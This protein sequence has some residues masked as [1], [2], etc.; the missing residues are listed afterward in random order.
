M[1]SSPALRPPSIPARPASCSLSTPYGLPGI[2]TP[3]GQKGPHRRLEQSQNCSVV[4]FAA[5]VE[6]WGRPA[7]FLGPRCTQLLTV[8][9]W[10]YVKCDQGCLP[11]SPPIRRLGLWV[12]QTQ[13]SRHPAS[14]VVS[15]PRRLLIQSSSRRPNS[16]PDTQAASM[17]RCVTAGTWYDAYEEQGI[18]ISCLAFLQLE[19]L[20]ESDAA[21]PPSTAGQGV[22]VA[23]H[24]ERHPSSG[25]AAGE[26]DSSAGPSTSGRQ[27]ASERRHHPAD[28]MQG[29]NGSSAAGAMLGRDQHDQVGR[30]GRPPP[31][32]ELERDMRRLLDGGRA[33]ATPL[34]LA[35]PVCNLLCSITSSTV[36]FHDSCRYVCSSANCQSCS[37]SLSSI[38]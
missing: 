6:Q 11:A 37:A 4:V 29:P 18:L 14:S 7:A 10:A 34:G 27:D 21:Q 35:L 12:P 36:L 17:K 33:G 19:D 32:K 8:Y 13:R 15:S 16:S 31:V 9:F 28:G 5:R 22:A 30:W 20:R 3:S 26:A 25:P 2:A 24:S 23:E 38:G 1:R